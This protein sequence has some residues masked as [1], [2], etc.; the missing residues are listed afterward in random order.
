[1]HVAI[2]AATIRRSAMI[3]PHAERISP[4]SQDRQTN[5]WARNS[6]DITSAIAADQ[7]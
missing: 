7:P 3:N 4:N 6:V 1:M 2:D 5:G